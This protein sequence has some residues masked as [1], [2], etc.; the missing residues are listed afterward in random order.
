MKRFL[1]FA[2]ILLLL[3]AIAFALSL[4]ND[5]VREWLTNLI[6]SNQP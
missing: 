3:L 6:R 2:G 1:R 4:L 5:G